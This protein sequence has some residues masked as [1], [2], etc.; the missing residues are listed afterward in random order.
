LYIIYLSKI[1][2]RHSRFLRT[3]T[4]IFSCCRWLRLQ[5]VKH[6]NEY[7]IIYKLR[8]VPEETLNFHCNIRRNE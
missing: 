6:E 5:Q 3:T 2:C 8:V 4:I 7:L 1:I